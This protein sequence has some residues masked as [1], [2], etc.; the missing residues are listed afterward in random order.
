MKISKQAVGTVSQA[1]HKAGIE[2]ESSSE[3]HK[4]VLAHHHL[5]CL[6]TY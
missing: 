3:I 4:Y 5:I 1:W 2:L 6:P